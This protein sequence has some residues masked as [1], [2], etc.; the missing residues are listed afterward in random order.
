[1]YDKYSIFACDSNIYDSPNTGYT[2]KQPN[3]PHYNRI[4]KE[5]IRFKAS[6]IADTE[7]DLILTSKIVNSKKSTEVELAIK[8]FKQFK[9]KNHHNHI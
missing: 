5:L 4:R 3:N 2:E 9:S 7:T 8:T 6:C 1:M